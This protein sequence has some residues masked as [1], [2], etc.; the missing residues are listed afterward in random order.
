MENG[1]DGYTEIMKGTAR[2]IRQELTRVPDDAVV[3]LIIGRPSLSAIARKLQAEA[4]AKGMT[5]AAHDALMAS[6]KDDR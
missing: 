1:M 2:E 4:A 6:L 3:R 5:A